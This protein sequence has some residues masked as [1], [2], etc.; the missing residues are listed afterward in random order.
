[1]MI[2]SLLVLAVL[3][4][5]FLSTA[6]KEASSGTGAAET[7]QVAEGESFKETLA[8]YEALRAALATD[9]R[10]PLEGQARKLAEAASAA[11]LQA[12]ATAR[13][14]LQEIASAAEDLE[15]AASADFDGIRQA[16]G[17]VSRHLVAL[18][19]AEP[20]LRKGLHVFECPMATGYK[21][22]VQRDAKLSNP[23]MGTRML[24]CGAPAEWS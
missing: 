7:S 17:E 6:C 3:G 20:P 14:H 9:D 11:A 8:S 2:R 15:K 19:V 22:W 23:Y 5:A 12:S 10:Q 18:L 1:M 4:A 21:K 13:P 24:E 16:F